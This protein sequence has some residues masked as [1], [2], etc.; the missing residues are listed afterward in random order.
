LG[1]RFGGRV[2]GGGVNV[3]SYSFFLLVLPLAVK[4]L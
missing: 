2:G 1:C 3:G 4:C